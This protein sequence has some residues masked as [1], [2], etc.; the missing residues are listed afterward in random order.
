MTEFNAEII[1]IKE[2]THD[3]KTFKLKL[4]KPINFAPGQYCLVSLIGNEEFGNESKPFTF[5][6]S[7]TE[8][9]FI[10]LTVKK[11][12]KFTIALHSLQVGDKLKINGPLGESLNFDEAI[13]DDIIFLA[14][15]SGITPFI[16][17]MRYA[18]AKGLPNNM[19]LFFSSRTKKDIIYRDELEK[20]N[21]GNIKVINTLTKES[22]DWEG[23]KGRISKE[24]IE[25]YVDSSKEKLWY[26]CG[27]PPMVDN[28]KK[29]L[30]EMD[31]PEE[32]IRIEGWQLPG[33]HDG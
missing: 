10:E 31:I 22:P 14:A 23:E 27:P 26:V 21:H 16:A 29:I 15:G 19:T 6:N 18:I 13:K 28:M 33:K 25:K 11:M 1:E 7:P 17:S 8:K 30:K 2:E 4:T 24:M 12:G 20:I 5:A 32:K 3:V 9:E